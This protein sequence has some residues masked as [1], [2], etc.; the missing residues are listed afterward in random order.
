MDYPS[1]D[2]HHAGILLLEIAV[3]LNYIVRNTAPLLVSIHWLAAKEI[4]R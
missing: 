2:A 3:T 4:H 1:Y